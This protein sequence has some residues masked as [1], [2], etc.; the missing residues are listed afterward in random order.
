MIYRVIR[1][2]SYKQNGEGSEILDMTSE[3]LGKMLKVTLQTC[4]LKNFR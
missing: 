4:A 3:G 1:S 2:K